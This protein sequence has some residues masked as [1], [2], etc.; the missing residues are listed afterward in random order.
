[1]T[2]TDDNSTIQYVK[3]LTVGQGNIMITS[4]L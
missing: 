1:M 4:S 2:I 3:K